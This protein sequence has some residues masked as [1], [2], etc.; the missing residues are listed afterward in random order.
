MSTSFSQKV[1]CSELTKLGN[2]PLAGSA[3]TGRQYVFISWSKKFW[4]RKQYESQGFPTDLKV[5]LERIQKDKRIFTR[6]V[7]QHGNDRKGYSRVFIMP[8]GIEYR[9]VAIPDIE[10]LLTRYFEGNPS[11]NY[12]PLKVEGTTLFCCTHGKRDRCCAKFGQAAV[13][14]LHRQAARKN[15]ELDLWEC[16]HINADRF[17][18]NAIVFPQGYMY[19]GVRVGHIAELLDNLI[20]GHPF[21]PCFRGQLGLDTLEQITQ[22]FGHAYRYENNVANAAIVIESIEQTSME[23]CKAYLRIE[24]KQTKVPFLR[25]KL[26]LSRKEFVSYIDCNA[27]DANRKKLVS[28]WVVSE[29]KL[30]D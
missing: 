8:D 14:E 24:N 25:F 17:A 23:E 22:A 26:T 13:Y 6:L 4:A 11:D 7:H 1:F 20:E 10:S 18:V 3:W 12:H 19:G 2:E 5:F 30:V 28:R 21:P 9:D 27:V 29:S 15:I 16:T